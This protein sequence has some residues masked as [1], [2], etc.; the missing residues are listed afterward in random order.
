MAVKKARAKVQT[1]EVE[2]DDK[3]GPRRQSAPSGPPA[4]GD[5]LYDNNIHMFMTDF[6]EESC[7]MAIRFILEKNVL[8]KKFRPKYLT[9]MINSPG[10]AVHAAFALI[11]VM[12][13][14]AIPVRTVGLG[15]IA[16][17]G[18]LTFMAGQK[19]HRVITPNTSILSHQYSWGSRGKEHELFAVVREFEMSTERM[20]THYKKCTGLNEKKIRELLLPPEDVWL[21]AEE[22]VKYGIAVEIRSVY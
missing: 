22:A 9:L 4:T 20:I 18:V 21:S 16:S 6:N 1:Q 15:M 13:G 5:P 12:K 17:C 3:A 11:D 10:G 8:P 7:A 14:S 19:G 2:T